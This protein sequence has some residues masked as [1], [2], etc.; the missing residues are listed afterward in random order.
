MTNKKII[1]EV[2]NLYHELGITE[3]KEIDLDAISYFKDA[4]V[5]RKPLTG[6]EARI[7]G[8][9]DRAIITVN[10]MSPEERQ[11]FSIGHELGHWF[12]DRGKIGNLC[13]KSD[14]NDGCAKQ[15]NSREN[16]ANQFASEFLMPSYLLK[17]QLVNA[18]FNIDVVSH[19]KSTFNTSFMVS[20]R[21][22]ISLNKFMGFWAS[23]KICGNRK[24]FGKHDKL[25]YI[26]SP[27][28]TVP[29][30][31]AIYNLINYGRNS[32]P[33][34]VDADIWCKEDSCIDSYVH[35]H[36]FHYH[37]DEFI[38]M[39]WWEDEEPIWSYLE[40]IGKF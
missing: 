24:Y 38:T 16:L 17:Q 6:C 26:F 11:R 32:G 34:K 1:T 31:S 2:Q 19:L 7:I 23:Y 12:K 8:G 28:K 14:I 3:A 4:E 20:L 15:S 35:E 22:V 10:N 18:S 5:K 36:A 40:G 39:I 21:K 33:I 27:P 37:D 30:G 13:S 25:P 9:N 29:E